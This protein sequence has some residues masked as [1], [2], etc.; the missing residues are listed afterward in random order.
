MGCFTERTDTPFNFVNAQ[1]AIG[2]NI[3]ELGD[4]IGFCTLSAEIPTNLQAFAMTPL[5]YRY[6]VGVYRSDNTSTDKQ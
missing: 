6:I 1:R 5:R 3:S 2:V 4:D